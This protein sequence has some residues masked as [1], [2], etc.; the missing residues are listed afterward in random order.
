MI[1]SEIKKE[2]QQAY[3]SFLSSQGLNPRGGQRQMIADI[4]NYLC[5]IKRDA[6]GKRLGLEKACV[7][8]AGTGTGK[9]LAY[10]V[11]TIPTARYLRKKLIVSTAT[12]TLQEQLI[13]KDLPQLKQQSKL[14]FDFALAKGRGRYLCISRLEQ[15]LATEE[16]NLDLFLGE[17]G[18]PRSE[19]EK[20]GDEDDEV[21]SQK[22][23]QF[24][25]NQYASMAWD[26]EFD[27][28][29][30]QISGTA[31]GMLTADNRSCTNRACDHFNHCPYY[32]ARG[33]WETTDV[34]VCNHDLVLADLALGG[35]VILPPPEDCIFVFDEAHHLSDK[36][37]SHF[38]HRV[39]L[40]SS[41]QWLKQ[42][43]KTLTELSKF[44]NS[45]RALQD[46]VAELI[47]S[48]GQID[49]AFEALYHRFEA[50]IR[51]QGGEAE[52]EGEM[53]RFSMGVLPDDIAEI[54]K[55]VKL[56]TAFY[57]RGCERLFNYSKDGLSE[58]QD[59]KE[60]MNRSDAEYW[61]PQMGAIY[62]RSELTSGLFSLFSQQAESDNI[63]SDEVE[64]KETTK[65]SGA[66]ATA[67]SSAEI[68]GDADAV[69]PQRIPRP[70]AKWVT[71]EIHGDFVD[72]ALSASPIIAD[73]IL[74]NG[75]WRRAFACVLTSATLSVNQMFSSML[76][77]MGLPADSHLRILSSPFNYNEHCLLQV[78]KRIHPPNLAEKHTEDVTA[79]ITEL[80][81][82]CLN[83]IPEEKDFCTRYLS[84]PDSDTATPV[85]E[86]LNYMHRGILVLFSS[87]KQMND[88][89]FQ[90]DRTVRE[91]ILRQDDMTKSEVIK[92]H[93]ENIDANRLSVLF[94]LASFAE[95]LDLPGRYLTHVVIA[96]LP[97][98]VPNDPLEA[99]LSEWIEARGGNPFFEITVPETAVR[100]KQ[101]CGRL[102]RKEQDKGVISLLDSRILQ[103]S[104]GRLLRNSLPDYFWLEHQA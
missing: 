7:I 41:R 98:A 58:E 47:T 54:I 104:Y 80:V 44:L 103:K 45:S 50:L 64:D 4:A 102:I 27:H 48:T 100:L 35:G 87:R 73:S 59:K 38:S 78:P 24:L 51:E 1:P 88:V 91:V 13:N 26:G 37:L 46:T 32:M 36:A 2:I 67:Q 8:E 56:L 101:A 61:Y 17:G 96:K 85:T 74:A 21:L 70:V 14:D 66:E 22:Q 15:L 95:G 63:D 62:Q 19:D 81:E 97:F 75:L 93:R 29:Q 57:N 43:S 40:Q 71:R 28:L 16:T 31:R 42:S 3:S 52:I 53:L 99:A 20:A 90:L 89:F 10:L 55:E 86:Y 83:Q 18:G 69:K 5:A 6:K 9:T 12:V 34:L 30:E 92:R 72:M 68:D 84:E 60:A 25:Y 23:L 79:F 77:K 49:S 82:P 11:S 76:F 94:G 33:K 65:E 39:Q